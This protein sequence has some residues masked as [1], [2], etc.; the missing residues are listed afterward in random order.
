MALDLSSLP[1]KKLLN[2]HSA[3][4]KELQ[5]RQ[6]VRTSNSP[7][8]DYAEWLVAKKLH[9]T[10]ATSSN[11]GFD[12]TDANNKRI[13]IKCRRIK[14]LTN[15]KQLGI[16][17]NI[18]DNPFDVLVAIIFNEYYDVV[19]AYELP[20]EIVKKYAKY[21]EH[22]KGYILQLRGQIYQIHKLKT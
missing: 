11:S 1:E 6:V 3:I 7:V 14:E 8:G 16:I 17:R 9:Y 5:E 22:Q 2:L 13:Q 18:N 10:L 20:I 21:S 4:M 12:A 15:S 19:E